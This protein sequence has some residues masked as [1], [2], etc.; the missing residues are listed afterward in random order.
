LPYRG[1]GFTLIEVTVVL[2]VLAALT[3]LAIAGFTQLKTKVGQSNFTNTLTAT[4]ASSRL[5]AQAK[6]RNVVVMIRS[7]VTGA[8]YFQLDDLS[9]T[10][11]LTVPANL[12]TL[13]TSFDPNNTSN[14]GLP[15]GFAVSILNSETA[16]NLPFVTAPNGWGSSGSTTN[17]FPFP[18]AGLS[19]D[20][21]AGCT[22]CASGA[23]AVAFLTDGRALFGLPA[24]NAAQGGAIVMGGGSQ[25]PPPGL[26]KGVFISAPSGLVLTAVQ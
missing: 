20:T 12:T 11:N 1:R 26:R 25:N 22:F 24:A 8:T 5:R 2:G 18:F 3:V 6:Q 13:A 21:S 23:G 14:Y 10:Q 15:A 17:S 4:L 16:T 9:P 19:V 7:G